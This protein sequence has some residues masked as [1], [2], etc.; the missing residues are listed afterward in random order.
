MLL[1]IKN[2]PIVIEPGVQAIEVEISLT[3]HGARRDFPAQL[4]RL[5]LNK[6]TSVHLP[7][8]ANTKNCHVFSVTDNAADT[9]LLVQY[10]NSGK[11]SAIYTKD[12]TGRAWER[13]EIPAEY[14]GD[15]VKQFSVR[16][17]FQSEESRDAFMSS[18]AELVAAAR[19]GKALPT[20]QVNAAFKLLA[21]SRVGPVALPVYVDKPTTTAK[22]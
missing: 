12:N 19:E 2:A 17:V 22:I 10:Q 13:R 3:A 21:K 5:E 14:S 7:F 9:T 20:K 1:Q 8:L 6:K 18:V 4:V 16:Y 11:I 15:A